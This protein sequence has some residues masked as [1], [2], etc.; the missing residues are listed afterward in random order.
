MGSGGI[1]RNTVLRYYR[2][3]ITTVKMQARGVLT[4]PKKVREA[5]G[6]DEQSI[7]DI[8]TRDGS[9][10]MRPRPMMDPGLIADIKA[11]LRDLKEGNYIEFSSIQEF[12]AKRAQ[13]WGKRNKRA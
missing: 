13:K 10:V 3:M 9:I 8:E 12:H 2:R 7:L 6:L 4:L 5:A 11:S 1:Y